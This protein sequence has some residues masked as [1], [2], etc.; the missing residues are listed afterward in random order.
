MKKIITVFL[1]I[2]MCLSVMTACSLFQFK[3]ENAKELWDKINETM[4]KLDSYEADGTG[5]FSFHMKDIPFSKD[6]TTE[7]TTKT[8]V[9]GTNGKD[10]YYYSASDFTIKTGLLKTETI[11][12]IE[13]FHDG[14]MFVSSENNG[15]SAANNQKLY[16]SLS[17]EEYMAYRENQYEDVDDI[18]F[19]DCS[20]TTFTHNEDETWS[21]LYSGYSP[22]SMAQIIDSFGLDNE[23][24]DFDIQDMEVN[25]QVDKKFRIKEIKI[26]FIFDE[27][28]AE[29]APVFEVAVQYSNYNEATLITNT[30]NPNN[31]KEIA[32]CRLLSGFED[33]IKKLEEDKDGSF[34]L[35]IEQTSF[36]PYNN[37][38]ES[39]T[40]TNH[41]TYGEKDG[42]Y[43]Y[44]ITSNSTNYD[45]LK[46][47][48][49]NGMQTFEILGVK[50]T[51][52]QSEDEAKITINDLI[53]TAK[54]SARYVSDI[55]KLEDGVYEVQCDDPDESAYRNLYAN[56]GG[57]L[58]ALQQTLKITVKDGNIVKIENETSAKGNVKLSGPYVEMQ[59]TLVS[60]NTFNP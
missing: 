44:N 9:S 14:K 32:D 31:Y 39:Y 4:E 51:Q 19:T 38:T 43:F 24:F 30:I 6:I 33:M 25:I 53:N 17:A 36:I 10:F 5:T 1:A 34:V 12:T 47:S 7:F 41:V 37:K 59:F 2:C 13:A 50:Q 29:T 23:V 11:K 49:A 55:K 20:N 45:N 57:T 8:I 52:E 54:Y 27:A 26:K 16:S 15:S 58:L 46:I 42:Q 56:Y 18:D 22:K 21:L 35:E 3:P 48:Y 28:D 60:T 40:E